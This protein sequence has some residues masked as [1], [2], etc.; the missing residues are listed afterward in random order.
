VSW[1][2]I[3]ALA[4]AFATVLLSVATFMSVRSGNRSARAAELSV[5]ANIRPLLLVSNPQDLEQKVAFN[6]QRYFQLPGSGAIAEAGDNAIYFAISLRNVATG[7]GVLH[8]WYLHPRRVTAE[9]HAPAEEFTRL[10]RD[11]YIPAGGVGF[12]QGTFRDP[13]DPAYTAAAEAIKDR[14]GI[15][16]DVLYGDQD[17]GQRIITRFVLAPKEQDEN[18][19]FPTTVRHW[20]VDR[21]DPF[22]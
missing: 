1:E 21:P 11:L 15:T 17:G 13:N 5:L 3:S 18:G 8:G 10:S 22:N 6:D 19:W 7:I 16:I 20:N 12:W 2:T 9:P 14:E 4:T